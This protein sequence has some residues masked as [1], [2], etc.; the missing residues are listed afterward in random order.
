MTTAIIIVILIAAYI[1]AIQIF[2]YRDNPKFFKGAV[3]RYS[4]VD[5]ISRPEPGGIICTGSS[6]MKYWN[7]IKQDLTPLPVINRGVAGTKVN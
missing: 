2:L 7:N 3:Q 5:E 6:V 1:I 4:K